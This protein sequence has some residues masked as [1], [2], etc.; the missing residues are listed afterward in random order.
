MLGPLRLS[1]TFRGAPT[2]GYLVLY[3][4]LLAV[5]PGMF[6]IGVVVFG[7]WVCNSL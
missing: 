7:V 6:A 3:P 2:S 1:G 4:P 5:A